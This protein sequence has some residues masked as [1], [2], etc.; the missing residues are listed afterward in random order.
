MINGFSLESFKDISEKIVAVSELSSSIDKLKQSTTS[1]VQEKTA[2]I[3]LKSEELSEILEKTSEHSIKLNSL[4][5]SIKE[6]SLTLSG[7]IEK[8]KILQQKE[9]ALK[10]NTDKLTEESR[11]LSTNIAKEEQKLKDLENN[12]NVFSDEFVDYVEASKKHTKLYAS[13]ATIP[14]AVIMGC[15]LILYM[16]SNSFLH[17][18]SYSLQEVASDF[19]LRIPF[20]AATIS[21]AFLSWKI[22]EKLVSKCIEIH[23]AQRDLSKLLV[24]AKETVFSSSSELSISDE[25]KFKERIRLKVQMIKNH[26]KKE[27]SSDFD[28]KIEAKEPD[29]ATPTSDDSADPVAPKQA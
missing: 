6:Q 7:L 10:S 12:K 22:C 13:L 5:E 14:L 8:T 20:S 17:R 11:L 1:E 16:N 4:T 27:I 18:G 23:Q 25:I 19:L 3:K 24:I 29:D 15:S 28:Y 9:V 26:L 2:E 21:V